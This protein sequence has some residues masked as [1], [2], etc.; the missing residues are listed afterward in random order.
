MTPIL[1]NKW[2]TLA[3]LWETSDKLP[4]SPIVFCTCDHVAALFRLINEANPSLKLKVISAAS[5]F[6]PAY[7][8]DFQ[9]YKDL[10]KWWPM[11]DK[12]GLG[13]RDLYMPARLDPNKCLAGDKFS[14]RSYSW[15][16]STFN[17]IPDN[18]IWFCTGLNIKEPN[19]LPIPFGLDEESYDLIQKYKDRPKSDKIF[20]CFENNTNE[21]LQLKRHYSKNKEFVVFDKLSKED[22]IRELCSFKMTLCP[23]GNGLD[24]YRILESLYA[25]CSPIIERA[26]WSE[27]YE[28][29]GVMY[30][31][32][33]TVSSRRDGVLD[34]EHWTTII[35]TI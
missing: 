12:S 4:D 31:D 35:K 30:F 15:T 10:D 34:F 8:K 19:A 32:S 7:Q 11:C 22:Y 17:K 25:G 14:I 24:S 27:F 5:D 3:P 20:V 16:H 21:R 9:P 2:Q 29:F 1:Y 6:S 28:E 33:N 13:Y 26:I 23:T 18:V